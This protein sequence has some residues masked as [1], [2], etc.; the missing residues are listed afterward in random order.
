MPRLID[1][2]ELLT[3]VNNAIENNKDLIDEWFANLITDIIDEQPT[4][5]VE[6][7]EK[8]QTIDKPIW[9]TGLINN[10]KLEQV[11]EMVAVVRCKDC[12][13]YWK[14]N[15]DSDGVVCL[16]TPKDDAYCSEGERKEDAET[17]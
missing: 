2:T 6:K 16:A 13:F 10:G 14:N 15:R 1:A 5:Q 9:N 3:K 11:Y 12:K 7:G 8:M 4:V 17:D